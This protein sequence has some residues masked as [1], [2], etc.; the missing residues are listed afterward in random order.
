MKTPLEATIRAA[1]ADGGPQEQASLP[2]LQSSD[3]SGINL[4]ARDRCHRTRSMMKSMFDALNQQCCNLLSC[5]VSEHQSISKMLKS[6]GLLSF[7]LVS[8]FISFERHD[9]PKESK[10]EDQRN[11]GKYSKLFQ[12]AQ[13]DDAGGFCKAIKNFS[14]A[15]QRFDSITTPLFKIFT[16][17]PS[18]LRFLAGMTRHGDSDDQRWAR[19]ILETMTAQ[20][21]GQSLIKS[22][23]S[24][25]A[26]IILEKFLRL[27]DREDSTVILKAAE[28]LSGK[29]GCL[30][31]VPV[32]VHRSG[33]GVF[34][35]VLQAVRVRLL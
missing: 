34:R 10:A 16:L 24:A 28:A 5:F 7:I 25:D 15:A 12:K 33:E 14:Y 21:G 31:V 2:I 6:F 22:A 17:F 23:M 30:W 4:I 8:G 20:D 35:F 19:R 1:V 11:S 27:D 26:F 13:L 3:L 29:G 9:S 32:I 18:M